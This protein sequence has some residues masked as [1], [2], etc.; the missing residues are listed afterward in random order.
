[1][2]SCHI[3]IFQVDH[4]VCVFNYCTKILKIWIYEFSIFNLMVSFGLIKLFSPRCFLLNYMYQVSKASGKVMY[5]LN[6]SIFPLF[7]WFSYWILELLWQCGMFCY[8]FYCIIF[9]YEF[10]SLVCLCIN[11][12]CI[13]S[14]KSVNDTI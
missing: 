7:L 9:G 13:D 2:N 12:Y 3:I 8:W 1:M 10:I 14:C 4:L 6:A 11:I 5:M